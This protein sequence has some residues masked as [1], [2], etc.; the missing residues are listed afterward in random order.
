MRPRCTKRKGFWIFSAAIW[1]RVARPATHLKLAIY[2]IIINILD[3]LQIWTEPHRSAGMPKA[4]NFVM[5]GLTK[6]PRLNEA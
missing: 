6:N 4:R 1:N 2:S 3:E 5:V